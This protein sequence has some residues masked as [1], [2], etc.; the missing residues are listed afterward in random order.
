MRNKAWSEAMWA[1]DPDVCLILSRAGNE[2]APM[3]IAGSFSLDISQV[4]GPRLCGLGV[5]P[6][7]AITDRWGNHADGVQAPT[8]VYPR[9]V[10]WGVHLAISSLFE[11]SPSESLDL[12]SINLGIR[13]TRLQHVLTS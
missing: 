1:K 6:Y 9:L 12:P 3:L 7:G 5:G 4:S 10:S 2:A 8:L 13:L 11:T